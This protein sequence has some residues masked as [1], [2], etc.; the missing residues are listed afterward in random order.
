MPLRIS[1]CSDAAL[2]AQ[3][4]HDTFQAAYAPF[5]PPA[6]M[7]AYLHENFVPEDWAAEMAEG[8][9]TYHLAWADDQ[10]AG[11]TKLRADKPLHESLAGKKGLYMQRLYVMPDWLYAGVGKALLANAVKYAR[12]SGFDTLWLQVWKENERAIAFY[13]RNGFATAGEAIFPWPDSVTYDWVMA[14]DV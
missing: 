10:P 8:H 14:L 6:Q 4:G 5:F 1:S 13:E 7:D 2:L 12:A 11:Y 3:I 9:C